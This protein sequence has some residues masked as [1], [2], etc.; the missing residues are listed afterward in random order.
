VIGIVI[1]FDKFIAK[2]FAD[3]E[4]SLGDPSK[5]IGLPITIPFISFSR[6]I[7][8]KLFN[9]SENLFLIIVV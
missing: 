7:L 1:F 4:D 8:F 3:C 2:S 6:M 5:F 9:K